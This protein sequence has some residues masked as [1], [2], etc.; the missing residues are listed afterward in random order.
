LAMLTG[1]GGAQANL[2]LPDLDFEKRLPQ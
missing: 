1:Q 2:P